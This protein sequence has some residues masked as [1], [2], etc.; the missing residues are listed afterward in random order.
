M[1]A[2]NPPLPGI[3]S[4]PTAGPP[5]PE[6]VNPAKPE[7]LEAL[8]KAHRD[9]GVAIQLSAHQTNQLSAPARRVFREFKLWR[10]GWNYA[11]KWELLGRMVQFVAGVV[12]LV[13]GLLD[14]PLNWQKVVATVMTFL[15]GVVPLMSTTEFFPKP[16]NEI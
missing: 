6:K 4:N 16:A 10:I 13:C 15:I 5:P 7:E 9:E 8:A 3:H 1:A 14:D 11:S 12:F 2:Y